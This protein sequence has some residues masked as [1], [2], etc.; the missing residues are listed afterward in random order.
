MT[1]LLL[2]VC[3]ASV[4]DARIAESAGADRL[5]LNAA[6]ALGGL[7]PSLGTLIEV[8]SRASLPVMVMIRPRSGG[9]HYS[10][11]DFRVMQRDLE[12]LLEHGADG[13]VFGILG[14]DGSIDVA[15][16]GL[17]LKQAGRVP[18]VFHRAFDVTPEPVVALEQ[19]IDLGFRRVMSSGQE[20]TA[21]NGITLL[22]QLRE[23]SA[24]RI[25]ILPAGGINRFTVVDVLART[26]CAQV[27]ASLRGRQSDPSTR[28]R[29]RISFGGA[30]RYPEDGFDETAVE[31]VVELRALLDAGSRPM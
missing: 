8:K 22:R 27:H 7:T 21:Y 9:F 25:E 14:P 13:V 24:S 2:E 23:R 28:N 5:E 12:L 6:L 29:P 11:A 26:G 3:I 1:P 17:L 18:C 15:R 19:L 4:E 20:E 31:S 30:L 16:C 10:D